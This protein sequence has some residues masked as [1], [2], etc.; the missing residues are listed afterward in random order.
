MKPLALLLPLLALASCEK[1]RN[2]LGKAGSTVKQTVA[3]LAS[4]KTSEADPALRKLVDET[5]DGVRFRKD[6]PF[7][8]KLEVR[9]S[10]REEWSGRLIQSSAIES[11]NSPLHGTRLTTGKLERSGN[12]IRH[13]QE[14]SSFN[15]PAAEGEDKDAAKTLADP[16]ALVT[17]SSQTLALRHNGTTW[18]AADNQF[19]SVAVAREIAP[20]MDLLLIESTLAP[21]PLWFANKRLK[22]GDEITVGGK[23]LPMLI[24]GNASGTLKLKFE[25]LDAVA[26]HPCGVFAVTGGY[27]RK[28]FPD[29]DGS[30]TDA[31]VTIQSGKLWLSLLHPLVLR[32]E[33]DTI[34]TIR[35]GSGGGPGTRGQ[36][37]VKVSITR[38]W[39]PL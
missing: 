5:A 27:A 24:A 18:V 14:Q 36:G 37:S 32:E 17:P 15:V 11:Q 31:E 38:E 30:F 25:N 1:A 13:T 23:S 6:L 28:Q 3:P 8:D 10:R 39:K 21:R 7:P 19:R 20:S 4:A 34:Q 35:T 9:I 12:Q 33:L 16:L 29:F 22:S 2:L 26:G